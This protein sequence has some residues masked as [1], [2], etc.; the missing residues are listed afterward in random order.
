MLTSNLPRYNHQ[1]VAE[2]LQP[3]CICRWTI[4]VQGL[5][6]L[7]DAS[8][9]TSCSKLSCWIGSPEIRQAGRIIL[10]RQN[11]GGCSDIPPN[12]NQ[13]HAFASKC[14]D[15]LTICDLSASFR[16]FQSDA[17]VSPAHIEKRLSLASYSTSTSRPAMPDR[18]VCVNV[19]L[20][21]RS[22]TF[23]KLA[24][25]YSASTPQPLWV[26]CCSRRISQRR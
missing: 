8:P 17:I 22:V 11:S 13:R 21:S 19:N 5:G 25:E 15:A 14:L 6:Y 1:T 24:Y 16:S 12:S 18:V 23:Q 20:V 9:P 2:H 3:C 4:G 10:A 26:C 7:V